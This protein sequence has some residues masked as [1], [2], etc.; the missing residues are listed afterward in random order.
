MYGST[1]I[2]GI[3]ALIITYFIRRYIRVQ[4]FAKYVDKLPGNKAYPLVGTLYV[5]FGLKGDGKYLVIFFF[6][7]FYHKFFQN[8]IP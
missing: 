8:L 7:Y 4:K 5:F 3:F 1:I 2:Y 6:T